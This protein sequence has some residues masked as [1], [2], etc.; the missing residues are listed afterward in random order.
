MTITLEEI[1]SSQRTVAVR[2]TDVVA[3]RS[4]QLT[5]Y[6]RASLRDVA[7]DVQ[8]HLRVRWRTTD[9][10]DQRHRGR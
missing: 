1:F 6:P 3:K 9:I 2:F 10:E 4:L 5:A 7:L 8:Q